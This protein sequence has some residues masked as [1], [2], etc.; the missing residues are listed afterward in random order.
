MAPLSGRATHR[1]GGTFLICPSC[2]RRGVYLKIT[3]EEWWV[4][5]YCEWSTCA[6][7]EDEWDRYG[8]WQL[9]R[10]NFDS[11]NIWVTD[12]PSPIRRPVGR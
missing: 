1:K 6:T 4:C 3:A 5:R 8:R 11:D 10:V 9:A 2:V 12:L 7:H